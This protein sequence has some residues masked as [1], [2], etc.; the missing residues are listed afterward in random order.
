MTTRRFLWFIS[1]WATASGVVPISMNS[2]APSGIWLATRCA[3]RAFFRPHHLAI[4]IG[5]VDR[6]GRQRRA[7]VVT[8]DLVL[9]GQVIQ[10]AANRLRADVKM[11]DQLFRADVTLQAHQLDNCVMTLCLLHDNP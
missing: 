3:M 1:A 10:I 7:A 9:V 2:V 4:V 5:S 6:A 8:L 11:F